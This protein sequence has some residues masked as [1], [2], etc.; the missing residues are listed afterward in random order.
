MKRNG[1]TMVEL[2]MVVVILGVLSV[3]GITGVS[4]LIDKA[5]EEQNLER[6]NTLK[7]AAEGYFQANKSA[8]P[9]DI[10]ERETIQ[11]KYLKDKNYLKEDIKNSKGEECITKSYVDVYKE[12]RTKY[13][14]TPYVFCGDEDNTRKETPGEA[15]TIEMYFSDSSGEKKPQPLK[16]VNSATLY[17]KITGGVTSGNAIAIDGYSFS[18]FS[19][20]KTERVVKEVYNSGSLSGGGK[21]EISIPVKVKDYIDITRETQVKARVKVINKLGKT[22]TKEISATYGDADN[23]YCKN[24]SG[25]ATSATD[26]KTSRTITAE[27]T[28]DD[29]SGCIRA[30]FTRTWPNRYQTDAEYAYIQVKDNAGKVNL[31][32]DYITRKDPCKE[33]APE[34][35]CRVRVNVDN[36]APT[37]TVKVYNAKTNKLLKSETVNNSKLNATINLTTSATANTVNGWMNNENYPAGLRIETTTKDNIHLDKWEWKT[38]GAISP[39][40]QNDEN[41]KGTYGKG[42]NA[43]CGL[44]DAGEPKKFYLSAEGKRT[45]VYTVKDKAGNTVKVTITANLDREAPPKPTVS[46]TSGYTAG[47]WTNKSITATANGTKKDKHGNINNES[48]W[49]KYSYILHNY[50]KDKDYAKELSSVVINKTYEGKNNIKFKSC[51]KAGN[52]SVGAAKEVWVDFTKP[53]CKST[54]TAKGE[55]P[56]GWLGLDKKG[57]KEKAILE[58]KCVEKASNFNSGCT[59]ITEYK[60]TYDSKIN[61]GDASANGNKKTIT[62]EDKAGNKIK[63]K[64]YPVKIDHKKPTCSVK[65]TARS[66]GSR[67]DSCPGVTIKY[68]YEDDFSGI[69]SH[70]NNLS[71]QKSDV[72][73]KDVVDNADNV[74]KCAGVDVKVHTDRK[75]ILKNRPGTCTSSCCG[76]K[77]CR[78][79]ACGCA[80]YNSGKS[81]KKCGSTDVPTTCDVWANGSKSGHNG[82]Q[83]AVWNYKTVCHSCRHKSFGCQTYKKCANKACGAKTCTSVKCCGYVCGSEWSAYGQSSTGCASKSRKRY[84]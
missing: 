40:L 41:K 68:T 22:A 8:L 2:L 9:K 67:Q 42:T 66:C 61:T 17:I 76:Y 16:N 84:T 80:T 70:P 47:K 13:V 54:K 65:K 12:T 1:F 48:N 20:N 24:L 50:Y 36:T 38:T 44:T 3:I 46:L 82:R 77:S 37:V 30:T 31:D 18:I 62:M 6:E 63:C 75:Y 74:G 27:C 58:A 57:I 35:S 69:K 33:P 5:K 51:D 60:Y 73:K 29:G 19:D 55:N 7:M 28:D 81:C 25:Q 83:C 10:G 32:D 11:A 14:Y 15:P 39:A 23:P 21:S 49:L 78:T 71:N 26:W 45:G 52:C 56:K 79:K 4:H 59:G 53:V 43:N 64:N 34:D 72:G